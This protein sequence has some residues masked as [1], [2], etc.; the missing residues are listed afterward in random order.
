MLRLF[1]NINIKNYNIMSSRKTN[2]K[3]IENIT[4][5]VP[6]TVSL[7]K[8]ILF[9]VSK[10]LE[11]LVFHFM[12]EVIKWIRQLQVRRETVPNYWCQM[13]QIFFDQN[14][15]FLKD[16]LVSKQKISYLLDFDQKFKS[17]RT[18]VLIKSLRN[19]EP[20]NFFKVFHTSVTSII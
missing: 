9:H 5:E 10:F 7:S 8:D 2:L 14:T 12:F 11:K 15:C 20:V 1:E 16:V 4:V 18:K 13:R 3:L 17:V 19:G 6:N